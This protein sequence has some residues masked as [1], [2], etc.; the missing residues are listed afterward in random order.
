MRH[1]H[2]TLNQLLLKWPTRNAPF[3]VHTSLTALECPLALSSLALRQQPVNEFPPL[4]RMPVHATR[5]HSLPLPAAI[6]FAYHHTPKGAIMEAAKLR[7]WWSHLQ[8]LDGRL[9]DAPAAKALEETGWARSVGGV[10]PYLGLR[11]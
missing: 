5:A 6:P 3:C 1:P 10:G 8:G 9:A 7:A 4:Q 11:A 2:P